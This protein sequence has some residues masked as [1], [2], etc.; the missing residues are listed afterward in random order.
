MVHLVC[1]ILGSLRDRGWT[2]RNKTRKIVSR[3]LS[4]SVTAPCTESVALC[5]RPVGTESWDKGFVATRYGGLASLFA[6][7]PVSFPAARH[8]EHRGSSMR[9]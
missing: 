7:G 2:K 5:P 4:W 9:N 1:A 6:L 8:P 3:C